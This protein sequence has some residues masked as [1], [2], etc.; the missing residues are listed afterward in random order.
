MVI[1][2]ESFWKAADQKRYRLPMTGEDTGLGA[3]ASPL[4]GYLGKVQE[5]AASLE[6]CPWCT[7]KG[8]TYALR[9][10]RINLQ[11]SVTLC[12]N[13]QCLFPLVSRSLEDVLACLDPVGPTVGTKRKNCSALETE[14]LI[15][16]A[17]KRLR[18]GVPDM[19]SSP[20]QRGAEG[21]VLN[22]HHAAPKTEDSKANGCGD[23]AGVET[24]GRESPQHED[25]VLV[26]EPA[27]AACGDALAPR[28]CWTSAA[29][30]QCSSEALLIGDRDDPVVSP[31][32]AAPG[33][34]EA[35]EDF[36]PSKRC[37]LG[38]NPPSFTSDHNYTAE[39]MPLHNGR[40]ARTQ[41]KTLTADVPECEDVPMESLSSAS[42]SKS[43]DLVSVANQP[44]WS[45]S[46]NLC[47]LD[48]LLVALVNC[49]SLIECKPKDEAEQSS[50][51]QL[52]RG[53]EDICASIRM[54]QQTGG[55]GAVKV[56][57]H[58]LEKADADLRCLRMSAFKLLQPK[59]NCKLGQ[60]E[61]PVFAM[62]LL[63]ASDP[64]AEPLF[65]STFH[66]MF[67]CSECKA[68]SAERVLKTL[69]T[70]TNVFPDWSPLNAVHSAPCNV[71]CQKNQRRTMVLESVPSV[72]ALHFVE[73]LP[74]N[75]VRRYAFTFKE[76]RYSVTTVIQYDHQLK[77][78]VTWTR[79]SD[80]S[81]LEY[82]DLKHPEC[83]SHRRFPVP[84]QEMHVVFWE[85][86]EE[87]DQEPRACFPS[88]T[89]AESPP[90]K[91]E[92]SPSRGDKD[93]PADRLSYCTP[94]WS[95]LRTP[96]VACAF[97]LADDGTNITDTPAGAVGNTSI[98]STTLLDTFEGLSHDDIVTLTL[99]ELNE[100]GTPNLNSPSRNKMLDYAPDSPCSLSSAEISLGRGAELPQP[101]ESDR[102]E[103]SS[104]D[105]S[106]VPDGRKRRGR[107]RG[108]RFT[109][110]KR[111]A[112][113][114]AAPK[115]AGKAAP[116]A[117]KA[118]APKAPKAAAP[119]APKAAA[120]KAA[121]E[122][123]AL[124]EV[125]L[126]AAQV[127][128]DESAEAA[129]ALDTTPPVVKA[130]QVSPVS[131][132]DASPL[133][134]GRRSPPMQHQHARWSFLLSKHPMNQVQRSIAKLAPSH[135]TTTT[136]AVAHVKPSRPAA[137][138]RSTSNPATKPPTPGGFA[139]KQQLRTEEGDG[140]PLKAAEM[141]DGF[142]TKSSSPLPPPASPDGKLKPF[143]PA[144]FNHQ[145]L[146]K[147]T[148]LPLP[149]AGL[150]PEINGP[151]MQSS[152]SSKPPPGL[153]DTEAL[154]YKL[155]K[156]LKAKK[157]KLAKL[158][159]MLGHNRAA[160]PRPDSTDLGSP[161]TVTS[162]TYDGSLC[163]D[164]LSDLLSPATTA[165]NLSPDS[166]GFLEMLAN[167]QDGADRPDGGDNSVG[168]AAREN[169]PS[170]EN[171]LEE[172]LSQAVAQR[173]SE[174]ETEA[175]SA[176]EL[177]V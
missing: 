10:Y 113:K 138:S 27:N 31:R 71:C 64:W 12:T 8:L 79:N 165:S 135:P 126:E 110:R 124:E 16:P 137:P 100:E 87:E 72:F 133:S 85:V 14:E 176:L 45:N 175:L 131:S 15:S 107:R 119:K 23:S 69:P 141:Y 150:L 29:R 6:H 35:E 128:P 177:F 174:M 75:D 146:L 52:M 82:D 11:E 78:F 145:T 121:P 97:S 90:F 70:F 33:T 143:Q 154:R 18:S 4:V 151:K 101:T 170:P 39:I 123:A 129:T 65:Q 94:D 111:S 81:W 168:S 46:D 116:K 173:P 89:F 148:P 25:D 57:R 76:S 125:A 24:A 22:G 155:I 74:D 84:A 54:H 9:S 93:L 91:K 149:R 66:W 117:P 99:V 171:F 68:A 130:Q 140:L 63:L 172:F 120:P 30:R 38:S 21:A 1:C 122:A 88:T 37:S 92:V 134:G 102:A 109:R 169:A 36:G 98:G 104:S 40:I 43:E 41:W 50:V 3:L 161:H 55:D 163:D 152:R 47:W 144:T 60:R 118:A 105:P 83:R 49:K 96:S 53:Y 51:W 147:N 7:S 42:P 164:F 106:F 108:T 114:A 28:T 112:A 61:T 13:P 26:K 115:A 162:S 127:L 17:H 44:F 139:P 59:L 73:G 166:T 77:H 103:G 62:P 142:L 160:G 32:H 48:S 34:P 159:E 5:R 153:S 167:G 95:L 67:R 158:N 86:E 80:G 56:P 136:T 156:K 20:A 19:L 157:K 58:V 132:T 2:F